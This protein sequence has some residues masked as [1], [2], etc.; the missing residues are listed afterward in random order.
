MN[1][2][3]KY[4]PWYLG[5]G[6][7]VKVGEKKIPLIGIGIAEDTGFYIKGKEL[8]VYSMDIWGIKPLMLPLSALTESIVVKGYNYDKEFVP[9]TELHRLYPEM[10]DMEIEY[11]PFETIL[12]TY[13]LDHQPF[14]IAK[15]LIS[16]GFWIGS[17]DLFDKAL[18]IDKRKIS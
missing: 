8:P 10:L 18:L 7:K 17:Q 3:E 12:T 9:S 6:L 14:W 11:E 5:T 15:Q 13:K 1:E 16:W 4:L 2:L